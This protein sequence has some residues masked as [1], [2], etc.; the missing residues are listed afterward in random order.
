MEV[1]PPNLDFE[2]KKFRGV[3]FS[4][5]NFSKVGGGTLSSN[6]IKPIKPVTFKN[7]V[8]ENNNVTAAS[9]I[10]WSF[11]TYSYPSLYFSI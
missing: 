6:S 9:E 4:R 2:F 5:D 11:Q 7:S 10:L 8:M 1:E 3:I